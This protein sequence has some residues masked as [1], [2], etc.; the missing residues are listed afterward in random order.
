MRV[1]RYEI[2]VDVDYKNSYYRGVERIY[3]ETEEE[4]RLDAVEVKVTSVKDQAGK[5]QGSYQDR[6]ILGL[7]RGLLR[8]PDKGQA[9]RPLQG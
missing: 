5:E 6:E 3:L 4:V 1:D 2:F 7:H 9:L 8:S